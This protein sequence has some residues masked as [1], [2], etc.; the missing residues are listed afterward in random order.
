MPAAGHDNTL[1][2]AARF[3]HSTVNA[4]RMPMA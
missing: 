3:A 4:V 1:C 2:P